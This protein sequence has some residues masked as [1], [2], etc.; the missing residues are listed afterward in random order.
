MPS[1][2]NKF[3]ILDSV[4]STNNYAMAQAHAALATHGDAV[5]AYRQ[6]GGKG[7]R[8]KTWLTGNGENIAISII[9]EPN[10][11]QVAE[12]FCLSAAVALG[13]HDFFSG[14]AGEETFI[15]WPNDIYW[16][17]RKAAGVL[18]ENVIG[19]HKQAQNNET[20]W[21]YAIIG[22]GININQ[23]I[24]DPGLKNVVSL[25]QITGKHFEVADLAKELHQ[26]IIK[27][28]NALNTGY[29]DQL[30]EEYNAL[31]FKKDCAVKLRKGNI[32]FD[33]VIKSVTKN[34][35]LY[36]VDRIDNFFDFGEVEWII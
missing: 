5:F 18:I 13:C 8:G 6:T 27:R 30:M 21:K 29:F 33:T 32:E 3:I 7:Q 9:I 22:I 10:Q 14:Y 20:A 28:T 11:L 1:A 24:F 36:T 26:K 4:D 16:R 31:L 2:G 35:Q 12:Q 15:K 25:K 17:D 23:A 34:G 19:K